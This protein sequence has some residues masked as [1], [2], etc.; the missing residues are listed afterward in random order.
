MPAR[1]TVL[2]FAGL[3]TATAISGCRTEA[4]PAPAPAP[5]AVRVAHPVRGL[6]EKSLRYV[7]TVAGRREVQLLARTT[8]SVAALPAPEGTSIARG[9]LVVAIASAEMDARLARAE[10]EW[11]RSRVE[12]DFAC[13]QAD[14]DAELAAAGAL[15]PRQRDNSRRACDAARAASSAA[16]AAVEEARALHAYV[17]ER[18][19]FDGI[20][21]RHLVREGEPVLPGR[22][23]VLIA[24]AE[25]D[26][27]VAVSEDDVPLG[28]RPGTPVRLGRAAPPGSAA[29]TAEFHARVR[30]VAPLAA[31]P[32]R[33]VEVRIP[34]PEKAAA[35]RHGTSVDVRFVMAQMPDAVSVPQ[36]A[37]VETADGPGLFV[38]QGDR[39]ALRPVTAGLEADG[40]VA[41]EP[42]LDP[43]TLVV[44]SHDPRLADGV[45]IYAVGAGAEAP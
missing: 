36:R 19:P 16:G 11:M 31:G 9:D 6:I 18:A 1:P 33:T 32:G 35:L 20:V 15:A 7:G 39:A 22:P 30:S 5:L 34:L 3:L 10:A 45:P 14:R 12:R 42:P 23:L 41:V 43:G 26:V 37:L 21:L 8:G 27:V 29:E 25:K 40:R 4:G 24:D 28:I 44:V 17:G 38:V 2:L 13:D